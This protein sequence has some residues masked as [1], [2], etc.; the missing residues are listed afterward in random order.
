MNTN[1]Q[2]REIKRFEAKSPHS[3]RGAYL[4]TIF[5]LLAGAL[6]QTG[7]G[8]VTAHSVTLN[9][10]PSTSVGV[11]YRVYRSTQSGASYTLLNSAPVSTTSFTDST[12]KN[13][14]TYFYVVTAVD[15][16]FNE[17]GYSSEV[18]VTIPSS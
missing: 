9:W 2:S 5:L 12:V 10:N 16:E 18:F 15:A 13:G 17:S 6:L 14:E 1:Q 11:G 4:L 8:A 3:R 7:C